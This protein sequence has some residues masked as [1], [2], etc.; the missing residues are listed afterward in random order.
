ME[1]VQNPS[2]WQSWAQS[3]PAAQIRVGFEAELIV[4]VDAP[5]E[6]PEPE[7]DYSEDPAAIDIEEIVDFYSSTDFGMSRREANQLRERMQSDFDQYVEEKLDDAFSEQGD[8]MVRQIARDYEGMEEEEID[9]VM[10]AQ[11]DK[12]QELA[13][14]A[15][16]QLRDQ[17]LQEIDERDWLRSVGIRRMT[18]VESEY[19]VTW[20]IWETPTSGQ[21]A[22]QVEEVAQDIRK[23]LGVKLY[24]STQYHTAPRM[25]DAWALEP[26]SS[27]SV[28]DEHSQAG[29]ELITPSP[30]P[31]L[32][33]SLQY[34][35]EV[36]AWAK[37][38]GCETNRTTG[39]HMSM[40]LPSDMHY[41]LDP[42]KLILLL[43]DEKILA[44]FGRSANT[45]TQS[46]F[47]ALQDH[48]KTTEQFPVHKALDA[49]R[50]GLSRLAASLINKPFYGKYTSVHVKPQYVEFRHAGGDYLDR[51]PEIK[52]TLLRMAYTLSVAADD[53]QARPEYAKKL[54]ALLSGFS[55]PSS[56][57][58]AINLFS[59]YSAGVID[60]TML[61]NSLKQMKADAARSQN[62]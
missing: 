51:L 19:N 38:Y 36:F 62:K 42:V 15:R 55:T 30:P 2:A 33:E 37:T 60:Q 41:K 35:D 53:A 26:D 39:F 10:D 47:K 3:E 61:K 34:L 43:G 11:S 45:Y 21:S 27:I 56:T 18:D 32:P 13:D 9:D 31:S 44:D 52:N 20:P 6:D 59:L 23:A 28:H 1:I 46:A 25:P 17:L 58:A 50:S 40:S 14:Q 4:P 54:Y 49:L 12:Y 57:D 29:L 5:M 16:D 7:P 48:I 24:A 8:A 22:H